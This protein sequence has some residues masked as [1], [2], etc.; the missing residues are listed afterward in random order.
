MNLRLVIFLVV[1]LAFVIPLVEIWT[2]NASRKRRERDR[3]VRG[4][5][6]RHITGA[7]QWWKEP[8]GDGPEGDH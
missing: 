2:H 6:L 1:L 7:R 3:E 8:P 4:D 5:N